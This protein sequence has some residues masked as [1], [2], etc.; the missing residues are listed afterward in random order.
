MALGNPTVDYFSLDIEGAEYNVLRTIPF[1]R[2]RINLFGVEINH[3]G[4]I[5]NGTEQDIDG[6][7]SANGFIH[8]AKSRLDKFYIKTSVKKDALSKRI[9]TVK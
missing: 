2:T 1:N 5:F 6:L 8:V 9:L 3:A 4:E 7:M